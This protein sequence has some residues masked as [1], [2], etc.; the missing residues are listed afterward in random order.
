MCYDVGADVVLS[1][2]STDDCYSMKTAVVSCNDVVLMWCC[3]LQV[4]MT[5]IAWT[6]G[7]RCGVM[8]N[9]VGADV[10][11]SVTTSTCDC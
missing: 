1:V 6:D 2:T 3:Q 8:C 7:D 4:P 9:D 11:L 5:A 10:V